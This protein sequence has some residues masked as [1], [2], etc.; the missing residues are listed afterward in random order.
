[1]IVVVYVADGMPYISARRPGVPSFNKLH[2]L[3]K[4]SKRAHKQASKPD[5]LP[6]VPSWRDDHD[7]GDGHL[8]GAVEQPL[9]DG[10]EEGRRLAASG[11][12]ACT[13]VPI[14]K[15]I[16]YQVGESWEAVQW[17]AGNKDNV[18]TATSEGGEG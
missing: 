14:N 4:A 3:F 6:R 10:Q 5:K 13:H 2:R 11:C 7:A 12:S 16:R 17:A 18:L 8:L 15:D 9:Q 1:M